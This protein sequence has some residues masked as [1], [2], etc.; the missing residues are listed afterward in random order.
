M[1]APCGDWFSIPVPT[2]IA[3][4]YDQHILCRMDLGTIKEKLK[5]ARKAL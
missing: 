1:K 2:A 3:A 4:D 5:K